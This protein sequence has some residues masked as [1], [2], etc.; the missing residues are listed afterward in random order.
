VENNLQVSKSTML[1]GKTIQKM[2][3]IGEQ[4]HIRWASLPLKV[5]LEISIHISEDGFLLLL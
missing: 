4:K 1:K 3:F 5:S 2:G